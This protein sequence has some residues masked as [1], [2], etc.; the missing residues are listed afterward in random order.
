MEWM[1]EMLGSAAVCAKKGLIKTA[2]TF[3]YSILLAD[4]AKPV[5]RRGF[6]DHQ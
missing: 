2:V 4:R 5:E 6:S 3:I 1:S